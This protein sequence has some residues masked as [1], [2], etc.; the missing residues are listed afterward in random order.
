MTQLH[1]LR[2]LRTPALF[3]STSPNRSY[4]DSVASDKWR[5]ACDALIVVFRFRFSHLLP[6]AFLI[7]RLFIEVFT[8]V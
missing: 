5:P 2:D 4:S 3:T 7:V 1:V 8:F 6:K